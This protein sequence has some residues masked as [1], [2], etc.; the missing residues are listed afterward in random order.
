ME[1]LDYPKGE[2]SIREVIEV[3]HELAVL[4]NAYIFIITRNVPN[5]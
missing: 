1:M 5:R 4:A 3:F 2:A